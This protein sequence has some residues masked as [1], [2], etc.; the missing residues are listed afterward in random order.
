MSDTDQMKA[1]AE[2]QQIKAILREQNSLLQQ[3]LKTLAA[4]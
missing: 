4:S 2:L 3:L 1:V